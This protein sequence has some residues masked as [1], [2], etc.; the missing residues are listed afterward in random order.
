MTTTQAVKALR[1]HTGEGLQKFTTRL[2]VSMT[3]LVK[4]EKGRCPTG[5]V[6]IAL[7]MVAQSVGRA[8]LAALFVERFVAEMGVSAEQLTKLLAEVR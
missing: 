3:S 7:A 8:D 1:A 5:R 2:G 6:L 4:Y